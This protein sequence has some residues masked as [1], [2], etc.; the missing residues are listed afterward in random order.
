[1]TLRLN[2]A[3]SDRSYHRRGEI[4]QAGNRARI[5]HHKPVEMRLTCSSRTLFL[6]MI[7]NKKKPHRE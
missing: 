7:G 3:F 2:A 4:T 5:W 1:M 6:I